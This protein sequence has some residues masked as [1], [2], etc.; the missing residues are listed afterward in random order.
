MA[1]KTGSASVA[2]AECPVSLGF[3]VDLNSQCNRITIAGTCLWRINL[4]FSWNNS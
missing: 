4:E 1:L 2:L 3:P